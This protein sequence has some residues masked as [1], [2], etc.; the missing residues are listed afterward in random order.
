VEECEDVS[1]AVTGNGEQDTTVCVG[2]AHTSIHALEEVK[3][4]QLQSQEP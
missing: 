2:I 1:I 3:P 4:Y